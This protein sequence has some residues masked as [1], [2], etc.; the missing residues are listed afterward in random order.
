MCGF[1]RRGWLAGMPSIK[2]PS[3]ARRY[4]NADLDRWLTEHQAD[5]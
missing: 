5:G 1:C 2:L 4:R 3:G